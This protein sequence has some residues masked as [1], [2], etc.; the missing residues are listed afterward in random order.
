VP[1]LGDELRRIAA[2]SAS[3]MFFIEGQRSRGRRVL[4]PKRGLLRGLQATGRT[5]A[6]LPIAL[7]YEHVPEQEA[8]DRELSGGPRSK[9]SLRAIF[10][11]TVR[12]IR[13]HI[14]LGR[15]HLTCGSPLVLNQSTDVQEL[16]DDIAAQLQRDT[17]VTRFHLRAF[18]AH[19]NLPEVDE[20]WLANAIEQRGGRV[21][22]SRTKV[23][24]VISPVL[25]Q[26]LQNQWMH[27]FYR[28]ALALFPND[29]AIRDHVSRH[30]WIDLSWL[31]SGAHHA[32]HG[33][34]RV[35]R[36]VRKLFESVHRD[37]ALAS[38]HVRDI[39]TPLEL[40]RAYPSAYLPHLEDA[41]SALTEQES[42]ERSAAR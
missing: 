22:D 33:D 5:F 2:R 40:V 10:K 18:L 17:A 13:G 31:T 24:P 14:K 26:N 20:A 34:A 1:E 38:E 35:E 16:A 32:A 39:A 29:P 41:F 11:W 4:P 30:A 7:C 9:M 25:Q 28:D 21:L 36:V 23:P 42:L 37:Y 27:W 3:L 12:L 6:V 8:F 15:V 19:A